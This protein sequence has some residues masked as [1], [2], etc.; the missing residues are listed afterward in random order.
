MNGRNVR[1]LA[2]LSLLVT[3]VAGMAVGGALT[4]AHDHRWF[5]GGDH[6]GPGGGPHNLFA[7]DGELG[8]RLNLTPQQSDSI[9]R[10]VQRERAGAEAFMR[11][12]RPRLRAHFDSVTTAIDGVLTPA[13]RSEF[14]RFRT[15]HRLDHHRHGDG[16]GMPGDDGP[17]L[18]PPPS[19]QH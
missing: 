2:I 10:I 12:M 3:F 11:E 1:L 7:P 19:G 9:G 8:K 15:E 13:Q 14:A 4:R 5:M 16:P 18:P 6:H 17:P